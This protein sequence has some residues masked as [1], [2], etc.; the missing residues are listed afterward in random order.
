MYLLIYL[1]F[2]LKRCISQIQLLVFSSKVSSYR[3]KENSSLGQTTI[4]QMCEVGGLAAWRPGSVKLAAWR[5]G[6][7]KLAAQRP[8]GVKL[9]AQRHDG[10]AA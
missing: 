2:T 1:F 10:L 7:V 6:G 3:R 4:Y 5:P 9:A 8:S